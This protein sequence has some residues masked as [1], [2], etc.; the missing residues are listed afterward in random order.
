MAEAMLLG[1]EGIRDSTFTGSLSST[2]V[3]QVSH[4]AVRHGFKLA[5]Y[6]RSCVLGSEQRHLAYADAL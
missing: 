4:F 2:H 1:F 3:R 6:K 5:D